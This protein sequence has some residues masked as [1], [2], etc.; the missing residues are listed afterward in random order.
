MGGGCDDGGLLPAS[1][2][3]PRPQNPAPDTTHS[4]STTGEVPRGGLQQCQGALV[5][6]VLRRE[7]RRVS[8][9]DL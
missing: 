2:L 6:P 1:R 8:T 4:L 9:G 5:W 7:G 3:T